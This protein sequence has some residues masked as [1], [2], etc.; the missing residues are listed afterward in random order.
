[1]K[2]VYASTPT[3]ADKINELIQTF[4]STIFPYYFSDDEIQ[5]FKSLNVLNP[6][7]EQMDSMGTLKTSYQVIASLQT[8]I[9]ILEEPQNKN[10]YKQIFEKNVRILEEFELFFPFNLENFNEEE[11]FNGTSLS[12]FSGSANTFLI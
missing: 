11:D 10:R 12:I 3:Q 9:S 7:S 6:T 2:V 8:I 4:Y 1:M 5:H